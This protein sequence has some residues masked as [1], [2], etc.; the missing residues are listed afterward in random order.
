MGSQRVG[1]DWV[2]FTSLH[3][4][5]KDN[6]KIFKTKLPIFCFKLAPFTVFFISVSDVSLP[7]V[8]DNTLAVP[9]ASLTPSLSIPGLGWFLC[10]SHIQQSVH[11]FNCLKSWLCGHFFFFFFCPFRVDESWINTVNFLFL[12]IGYLQMVEWYITLYKE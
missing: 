5:S 6:L 12:N 11:H 10:F 9:L 7:V 8:Q 1:H 4:R 3:C 2:T